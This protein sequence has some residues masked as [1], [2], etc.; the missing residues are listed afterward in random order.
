MS[1]RLPRSLSARVSCRAPGRGKCLRRVLQGAAGVFQ[2]YYETMKDLTLDGFAAAETKL[3]GEGCWLLILCYGHYELVM[4][5]TEGAESTCHCAACTSP[6]LR[7]SSGRCACSPL[8]IIHR[9][10]LR[11]APLAS[12]DGWICI[13]RC[14][15]FNKVSGGFSGLFATLQQYVEGWVAQAKDAIARMQV[16]LH[17]VSGRLTPHVAGPCSGQMPVRQHAAVACTTD[18][19]KDSDR[20]LRCPT[21]VCVCPGDCVAMFCS[22]ATASAICHLVR[23]HCQHVS[24]QATLH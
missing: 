21:L 5:H 15:E 19:R 18:A 22:S 7:G 24:K 10:R 11:L 23:P 20:G 16:L 3:L 1:C 13:A 17:P 12:F 2:H 14:A 4:Q 9:T 6:T 8:S